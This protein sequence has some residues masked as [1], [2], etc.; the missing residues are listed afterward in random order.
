MTWMMR[1]QVPLEWDLCPR[2]FVTVAPD[3]GEYIPEW[4]NKS[5]PDCVEVMLASFP[6]DGFKNIGLLNQ[7][8]AMKLVVY[9]RI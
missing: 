2:S 6:V 1:G 4:A 9:N 7:Q 8:P 3:G 5:L